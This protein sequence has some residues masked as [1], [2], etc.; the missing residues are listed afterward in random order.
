MLAAYTVKLLS[1]LS[2]YK[3]NS[4]IRITFEKKKMATV[5]KSSSLLYTKSLEV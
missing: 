4:Q 1:I 3:N 2:V 5:E